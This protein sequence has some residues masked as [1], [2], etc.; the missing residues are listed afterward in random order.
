MA[1]I[2]VTAANCLSSTNAVIVQGT[3]G[4]TV[5][6]GKVVYKNSTDNEWYLAQA[7]GTVAEADAVGIALCGGGNA[8]PGLIQTRGNITIGG[9]VAVG[10][11]YCVSATAG[12]VAPWSDLNP[13]EYVTVLGVGISASVI[14]MHIQASGVVK[15][16]A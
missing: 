10:Q 6:A 5:V 4:E 7:D 9:T 1:D 11:V 14:Q 16:E 12:G 2:T 3:F 8:Q 13:A 15:P